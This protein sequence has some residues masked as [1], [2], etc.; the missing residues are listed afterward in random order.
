MPLSSTLLRE[1][2]TAA[3]HFLVEEVK[4]APDDDE[5]PFSRALHGSFDNILVN[6]GINPDGVEKVVV[7]VGFEP[8][9]AQS[10][11]IYSPHPFATWIPYLGK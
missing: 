11:R 9:N 6:G 7:G 5:N 8:T 1:I 4:T 10:G 2:E 3:T